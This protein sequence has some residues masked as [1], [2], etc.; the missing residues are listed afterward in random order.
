MIGKPSV[1]LILTAYRQESY[2]RQAFQAVLDQDYPGLDILVSDDCSPDGTFALIEQMADAYAGPHR[3]RINRNE[4]NLGITAHVSK[5]LEMTDSDLIVFAAGDDISRADR[6]ARIV[7]AWT[8]Q[9]CPT[10]VLY[11]DYTPLSADGIARTGEATGIFQGPHRIED[12]ADG[13]LQVLGATTAI[14]PDLRR[15]FPPILPS[16][17]YEDRIF[18]F[19]AL[20]SGGSIIFIG[21]PLVAYRVEV[22]ISQQRAADER[23]YL[24]EFSRRIEAHKLADAVQRFYDL[25]FYAPDQ[26]GLRRRCEK[27]IQTHEMR[28]AFAHGSRGEYESLL[29]K[30]LLSGGSRL[31]AV[32]LYLKHRLFPLLRPFI[33]I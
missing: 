15:K 16:A 29:V 23:T 13:V 28:L 1:T 26:A 6:V 30:A 14:T 3:L 12:M 33:R 32:K 20:L 27:T 5:L 17:V 24:S 9:G 21:E 31:V 7:E 11:S 18:P 8:A 4:R 2:I 19:R 10:A 25:C 22:G